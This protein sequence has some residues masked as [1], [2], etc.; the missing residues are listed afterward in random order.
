MLVKQ[1]DAFDYFVRS[2]VMIQSD[3]ALLQPICST[4]TPKIHGSQLAAKLKTNL[5]IW[6]FEDEAA[7]QAATAQMGTVWTP[8]FGF[9]S[10]LRDIPT[11]HVV[12]H[13]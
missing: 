9:K 8:S 10:V 4:P 7:S 6:K 12:Y 2:A 3:R 11:V 13:L 5:G 1:G